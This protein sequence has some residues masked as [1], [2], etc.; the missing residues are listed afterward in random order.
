MAEVGVAHPNMGRHLVGAW[1]A[2]VSEADRR[3]RLQIT[4]LHNWTRMANGQ[5]RDD[6]W[7]KRPT[8]WLVFK[9]ISVRLS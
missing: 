1:E 9:G 4:T 5:Y 3:K 6:G 2:A 7:R 8:S